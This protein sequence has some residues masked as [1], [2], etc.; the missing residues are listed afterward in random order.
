[1]ATVAL[2]AAL[3]G[4]SSGSQSWGSRAAGRHARL[5]LVF[6][7]ALEDYVA[8]FLASAVSTGAV[9]PIETYKVR[10]QAGSPFVFGSEESPLNLLQGIELGL[11]KE[12][13]NAAIYLGA[14]GY[15][16]S[17]V[18]DLPE[19]QGREYDPAVLFWVALICGALGDAAGSP[20]RLPFEL[21]GK[22]IQAGRGVAGRPFGESL[23]AALPSEGRFPFVAQTWIAVL[24]RDMPFG[25]L[26]LCFYELAVLAV[27]PL[28]GDGFY[29]HLLEGG[30][31]GGATAIVTTPI[32]C[33]ITRLML[34]ADAGGAPAA[35]A[36][37]APTTSGGAD[38]RG[39]QNIW[40][41]AAA[42]WAEQGPVGF[43]RG[44]VTR[45]AQFAPA[46]MLFFT[47]Y[48]SLR[49]ALDRL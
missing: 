11:A 1:M 16:R 5:Q 21:V 18:L 3:G 9:Y 19:L 13:P 22:N 30:I 31:A 41:A 34:V 7:G 17:L 6:T 10:Q 45:A 12:C 33:S 29:A 14:Y 15:L 27:A 47:A 20:L 39:V 23:A 43:T 24:A 2:L 48:E 49:G 44:W 25:A 32:D 26:Q 46:A 38:V 4:F 35:D 36:D 37:A 28:L 42:V 40:E 8:G